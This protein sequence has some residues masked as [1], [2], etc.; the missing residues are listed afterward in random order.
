MFDEMRYYQPDDLAKEVKA[1]CLSLSNIRFIISNSP[2]R[3][4]S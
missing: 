3:Q 4:S 1:N 2:Q